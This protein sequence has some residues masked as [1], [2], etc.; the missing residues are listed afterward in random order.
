MKRDQI[1]RL[2]RKKY[3]L[4]FRLARFSK[5]CALEIWNDAETEKHSQ[6]KVHQA[7]LGEVKRELLQIWK[8]HSLQNSVLDF[9]SVVQL[10]QLDQDFTSQIADFEGF[11]KSYDFL[12]ELHDALIFFHSSL[13]PHY[14]LEHE[15]GV[16]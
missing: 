7:A 16:L 5:S 4:L 8:I 12:I 10:S 11:W 14:S 13:I 6:S 9:R 2:Y 15:Q 3:P 1:L